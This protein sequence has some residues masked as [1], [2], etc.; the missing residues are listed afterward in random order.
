MARRVLPRNARRRHHRR[1][2]QRCRH[3]RDR[4]QREHRGHSGDQRQPP[5][6]PRIRGLRVHVGGQPRRGRRQQLLLDGPLGVLEPD[7]P[8]AGGRPGGR[9]ACHQIRPGQGA[10]GDRR[11]RQRGRRHRQPE[12][13]QRVSDGCSRSHQEPSGGR[14]HPRSLHARRGRPG[15]R[16]QAGLRGG[17]RARVPDARRL[18]QLRNDHR[19]RRS[20]RPD[21]LDRSAALLPQRVRRRGWNVHGDPARVR[22]RRPHQ[23]GPPRVH[24]RAGHRPDAQAGGRQLR[25]PQRPDR[26][27]RIPGRRPADCPG[28][29]PEGP[30]QAGHRPAR[31]LERRPHLA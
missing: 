13:R 24:G 31:V 2:P 7:R 16:R 22:R 23:V 3:R 30:A 12:H 26:L 25:P 28:R 4:P 18:L 14:F 5:H 10:G 9:D 1:Q 11:R 8:R 19:L 6:L 17:A 29:G 27:P 20:G 21:L 15:Q